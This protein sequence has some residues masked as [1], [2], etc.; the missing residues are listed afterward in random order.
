MDFKNYYK[1]KEIENIHEELFNNTSE[2]QY[3]LLGVAQGVCIIYNLLD[4]F[5]DK[6]NKENIQELLDSI[7]K[8]AHQDEKI[9]S[10]F[11]RLL[12]K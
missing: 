2:Y 5:K 12:S 11:N 3:Y 6:I 8:I 7:K 4:E 1:R 9:G 10:H